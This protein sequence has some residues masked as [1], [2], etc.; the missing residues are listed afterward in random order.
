MSVQDTRNCNMK[1]LQH[2]QTGI[3]G[4]SYLHTKQLSILVGNKSILSKHVVVI[5]NYCT[6]ADKPQ[7]KIINDF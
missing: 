2:S 6:Q 7:K 3:S 4:A 5:L 1:Q